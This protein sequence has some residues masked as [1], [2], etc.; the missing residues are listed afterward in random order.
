MNGMVTL[1][2]MNGL[3]TLPD[4]EWT[5]HTAD[6]EWT[7]HTADNSLITVCTMQLFHTVFQDEASLVEAPENVLGNP[8][9]RQ[10][11]YLNAHLNSSPSMLH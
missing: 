11:L 2:T 8:V 1:R 6:N 3:I 4:N 5:Y 10:H 7:Y 9:T